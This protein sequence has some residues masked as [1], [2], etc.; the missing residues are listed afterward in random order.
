MH[1]PL[2]KSPLRYGDLA[3]LPYGIFN[4]LHIA[5]DIYMTNFWVDGLTLTLLGMGMVFSFLAL[6]VVCLIIMS[7]LITKFSKPE[8]DTVSEQEVAAVAVAALVKASR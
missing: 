2:L 8:G 5:G 1:N 7:A 3:G 4:A 6:L